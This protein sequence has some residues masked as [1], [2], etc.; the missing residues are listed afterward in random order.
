MSG[1]HRVVLYSGW[2]RWK[3]RQSVK[4]GHRQSFDVCSWCLRSWP[5]HEARHHGR[6]PHP[7][8]KRVNPG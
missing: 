7:P 5:C 3:N 8:I 2:G 6:K 4:P 1:G